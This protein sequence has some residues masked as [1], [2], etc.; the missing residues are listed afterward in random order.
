MT[1]EIASESITTTDVVID[2]ATGSVEPTFPFA[3]LMAVIRSSLGDTIAEA[4]EAFGEDS[5]TESS[6]T[7]TNNNLGYS[8]TFEGDLIV[9]ASY[10]RPQTMA[11]PT[12]VAM[13]LSS[14]LLGMFR[15]T[16]HDAV[17]DA[18]QSGVDGASTEE[19]GQ[20]IMDAINLSPEALAAGQQVLADMRRVSTRT[21]SAPVRFD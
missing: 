15:G 5:V 8:E 21:V 1:S 19:V 3:G 18:I 10:P 7:V 12:S 13:L 4:R 20:A 11:F 9:G 2:R 16:V 14:A 6:F 17:I